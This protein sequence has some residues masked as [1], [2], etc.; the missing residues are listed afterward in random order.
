MIK[1]I[2]KDALLEISSTNPN[3]DKIKPMID[4]LLQQLRKNKIVIYPAGYLGQLLEKTLLEQGIAINFY[5]DRAADKI[6]QINNIPVFEPQRLCELSNDTVVLVSAN[7]D[8]MT[9]QLSDI[10]RQ[11]NNQITI[12][13]G[14]E[15]NRLLRYP[16]C[17]KRIVNGTSLDLV[18]C[19]NCGFERHGCLLCMTYL[20]K[21]ACATTLEDD[22]RSK[23]FTWFGYIVGQACTL[24]CIHCCEAV[25]FQKE[26]KFIPKDVIIEDVQ[27]VA[28]SSQFLTFVELIGGEPFMHPD[29]KKLVEEL[30]EIENIGYIKSFTNGTI[31]PS[32]ELCQILKNPRFML[33]VSN[34]EKQAT[35]KLLDNI[36]ATRKILKE[37]NVPYI[38]TQNFEW[39]DFTPFD[40]HN[41]EESRLKAVFD[42]CTLRNC[43]RLYQSILYRCPHQYA[44]VELGVLE[45]HAV[46]CVDINA[47]NERGLADAI[48]A[49]E[50]V[51]YIDAC[52]YCLM[53]FDAPSVP[54]GMQL[55]KN[56]G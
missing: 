27:K 17:S 41:T 12:L 13:N 48:E 49:F 39:Q 38:F 42:A 1:K 21:V 56:N 33:Q 5:I 40:L 16:I 15:T 3:L 51:G 34:Y 6:K 53:P 22:W 45:K 50:N 19:E 8:S 28:A 7:L 18:E 9:Q 36:Y 29:Y 23:S 10:V 47:H 32:V 55:H 2:I 43:N 11:Y 14:F 37:Q 35:G 31:V 24:K 4:E 30:L 25:P 54:A 46:E 44:G 26:H 52:R 20:K